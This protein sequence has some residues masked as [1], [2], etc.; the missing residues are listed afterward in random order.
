[1]PADLYLIDTSVWIFTLRKNPIPGLKR[2]IDRLLAE[3]A[4]AIMGMIKLELLG[5][6]KTEA[7]HH[8]LRSRL[9]ALHIIETDAGLWDEASVLAFQLR[10]Q[11]LTIPYT[12]L[13]IAS[14]ALRANAIIIHAD[15]HFDEI[16]RRS[17]LQ[18]ESHVKDLARS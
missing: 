2:R 18:V 1:M 3:N 4:V 11:G 10:R 15:R 7:E 13:L 12:D 5:G 9:D 14:G 6:V 8:R 16:A 17:P